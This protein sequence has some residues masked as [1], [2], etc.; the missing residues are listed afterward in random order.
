MK[1]TSLIPVLSDKNIQETVKTAR[2]IWHEH[3][4]PIIGKPQVEYMLE[5]F[6]SKKAIRDQINQGY[7]YFALILENQQIG[8]TGLRLDKD[9]LF[10]SK[11]YIRKEQRGNGFSRL[12]FA[13][14]E[15][16]ARQNDKQVMRLT[17]NKY[18]MSSLA[19]YKKTGFQIVGEEKT[20]IGNGFFMDDY[21]LEKNV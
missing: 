10:I 5:K 14:A 8:Y 13:L 12:M 3:F 4:T 15:K 7:L 18:N 17:C 19:V 1:Q 2:I 16:T 11:L 21:I 20:D 6:Q 9:C